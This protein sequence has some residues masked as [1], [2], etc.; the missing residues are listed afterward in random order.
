MQTKETSEQLRRKWDEMQRRGHVRFV[1]Q[2]MMIWIGICTV[3]NN[4]LLLLERFAGWHVSATW[5]EVLFF[6]GFLGGLS[7]E[8]FWLDLKRKFRT[9]P[10]EEDWVA[11]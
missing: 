10:P 8:I 2:E 4:I 6:G 11:R 7:S 1:V 3:T 9:P 5:I